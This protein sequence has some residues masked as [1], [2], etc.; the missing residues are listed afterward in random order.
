MIVTFMRVGRS[1]PR[2]NQPAWF[3]LKMRRC[4][5][6]FLDTGTPQAT[7]DT[8]GCFFKAPAMSFL[9]AAARRQRLVDICAM[10][11]ANLA[12]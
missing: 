5:F 3:Q 10:S 2:T 11:N 9:A 6:F 4:S 12:S 8:V 7:N 1:V